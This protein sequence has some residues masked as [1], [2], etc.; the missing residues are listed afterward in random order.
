MTVQ[1]S[2]YNQLCAAVCRIIYDKTG[3]AQFKV[4]VAYMFI[5]LFVLGVLS[6]GIT[7][8]QKQKVQSCVIKIK[9]GMQKMEDFQYNTFG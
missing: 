7:M 4:C 5:F 9:I 6:V 1:N 8:A 2:D 3:I